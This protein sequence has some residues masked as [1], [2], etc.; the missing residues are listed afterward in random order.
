M[1][2]RG[3]ST[4]VKYQSSYMNVSCGLDNLRDIYYTKPSCNIMNYELQGPL[5]SK[6]FIILSFNLC[7]QDWHT[8]G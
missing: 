5:P 2:V 8:K 4:E 3:Q 7:K 1:Y 6:E